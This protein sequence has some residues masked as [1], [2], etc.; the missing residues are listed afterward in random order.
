MAYTPHTWQAREG[1]GLSIYTDTNTGNVLNLQSTP[2]SVTQAGTPFSAEWMNEMEQGIADGTTAEGTDVPEA[3]AEALGDTTQ[4]PTVNS[5]L[6]A[7]ADKLSSLSSGVV[8]D[9]SYEVTVISPIG[10]TVYT[11][12]TEFP[13]VNSSFQQWLL[14][15]YGNGVYVTVAATD[16]T[17]PDV[18]WSTDFA[19]WTFP[20]GP[21][22]Q[23]SEDCREMNCIFFKGKFYVY[24]TAN[25]ST[26]YC[27]SSENGQ[28]WTQEN[29]VS[30]VGSQ[31]MKMAYN[32]NVIVA[33]PYSSSSGVPQYSYDGVT[34]TQITGQGFPAGGS[35]FVWYLNNT[36]FMSAG[37][38]AWIYRST[39]GINWEQAGNTGAGNFLTSL[40]AKGDILLTTGNASAGVFFYSGD[41]GSTWSYYTL[42]SKIGVSSSYDTICNI[43]YGNG[44]FV[45]ALSTS[46]SN[47][48][49]IGAYSTDGINW[50]QIDSNIKLQN[51]IFSESQNI[52]LGCSYP[53]SSPSYI[54][55]SADGINWTTYT[56]SGFSSG[57][58]SL[59]YDLPTYY[60]NTGPYTCLSFPQYFYQNEVRQYNDSLFSNGEPIVVPIKQLEQMPA[61]IMTGTYEGTGKW[62]E[63]SPNVL[64]FPFTPKFLLV[65]DPAGG[66]G[67]VRT[68]NG[69]GWFSSMA[70][71]MASMSSFK[72]SGDGNIN[73]STCTVTWGG[74]KISWYLPSTETYKSADRQLNS[75]GHT[76]Y[77]VAIGE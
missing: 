56:V 66:S 1:E 13:V 50:T 61:R 52:F 34:W 20:D 31:R 2:T 11:S 22:F 29:M 12:Q 39:D 73:A 30:V 42:Y 67:Y 37:N 57:N 24:I 47:E 35:M 55:T 4:P 68:G 32:A 28:T 45:A 44:T 25:T 10:E 69:L 59:D 14:P 43:A 46:F 40:W 3:T 74:T 38:P 54:Y 60:G 6:L 26:T 63:D 17:T 21:Q 70:F 16:G 53:S 51:V 18:A 19:T 8:Y 48:N 77:Y 58:L 27:Y 36:F 72:I 49:S 9:P 75:A 23:G 71:M 15:A 41:N 64:N 65:Q 76:Y 33:T 5:A 7:V 62:G